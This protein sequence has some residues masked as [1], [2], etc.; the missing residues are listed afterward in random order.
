MSDIICIKCKAANTDDAYVCSNCE[1]SLVVGKLT[2]L[3][4]GVLPK[5]FVWELRPKKITVGTKRAG[6][7]DC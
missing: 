2:S 3:G 6:R 4:K 1:I 5:G 7:M